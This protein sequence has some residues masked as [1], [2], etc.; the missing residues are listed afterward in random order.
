MVRRRRRRI[1]G[2]VKID[3]A[4]GPVAALAAAAVAGLAYWLGVWTA[5]GQ[6]VENR[7][8]L[9]AYALRALTDEHPQVLP[10]S[11][12]AAFGLAVLTLAIIGIA[13][14]RLADAL[15]AV[16]TLLC[17]SGAAWFLKSALPRPRLSVL[18]VATGNSFPSGHVVL[19]MSFVLALLLV[20]PIR[21]R[22]LAAGVG[23]V[24]ACLVVSGTLIAAWHRPSDAIGAAMVSLIFFLVA[25]TVLAGEKKMVEE[26]E[27]PIGV[28]PA[29]LGGLGCVV[30]AVGCTVAFQLPAQ[31]ST[32]DGS[33]W[34]DLL[35]ASAVTDLAIVAVVVLAT[36]WSRFV[37]RRSVDARDL[38]RAA[39]SGQFDLQC[40][41]Y[42]PVAQ[43]QDESAGQHLAQ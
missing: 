23:A 7:I 4:S 2:A 1:V 8:V 28:L 38:D 22:W 36:R 33:P 26:P 30:V 3:R 25:A 34:L 39:A 5:A 11:I 42:L 20:V 10:V 21:F 27:T 16:L 32:S 15:V 43:Q 40:C 18:S 9:D 35:L 37:A 41:R 13:R 14:H 17:S 12:P 19:V 24:A 29:V 31:P 6:Q